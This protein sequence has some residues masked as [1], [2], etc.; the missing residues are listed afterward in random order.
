MTMVVLGYDR[1]NVIVKGIQASRITSSRAVAILVALWLF[2]S[3]GGIP[4]F[5][6]WGDYKLEG[7]FLTCSYDYLTDDWNHKSFM[8]YAFVCHYVLPMSAVIFFYSQI[9]IAVVTHE[10]KIRAQAK[11][12]N[13]DSLRSNANDGDESAEL[14]IGK[15]IIIKY[16][17]FCFCIL[18]FNTAKVAITNV[19]LWAGIWTPYAVIA[20][21][22]VFGAREIVTPLVSQIPAFLAKTASCFNPIVFA[23]SHPKYREAIFE[24]FGWSSPNSNCSNSQEEGTVATVKTAA[25]KKNWNSLIVCKKKPCMYPYQVNNVAY[26]HNEV[27][28]KFSLKLLL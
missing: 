20:M 12:M 9:V 25:W 1:Y 14:K 11:K 4:P 24:K 15:Y 26:R 16:L 6:G 17:Q 21:C 10:A 13:V 18:L 7:L 28:I 27:I 3:I 5:F 19:C 2:S 22:P 23:S 8:I